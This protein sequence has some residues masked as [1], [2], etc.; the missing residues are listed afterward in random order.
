MTKL[1]KAEGL[2]SVG[3]GSRETE[4]FHIGTT[5]TDGLKAAVGKRINIELD[6]HAL[7]FMLSS[8]GSYHR[9]AVLALADAIRAADE[10][11]G[12]PPDLSTHRYDQYSQRRSNA[13]R[14]AVR[15]TLDGKVYR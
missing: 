9:D 14:D 4:A 5:I 2:S 13:Y 3:H 7:T 6:T 11:Y 10:A 15:T 12:P 8:L 1:F